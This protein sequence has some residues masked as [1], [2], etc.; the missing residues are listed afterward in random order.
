MVLLKTIYL[1]VYLNWSP[2]TKSQML[3]VF[4]SSS[5]DPQFTDVEGGGVT[6]FPVKITKFN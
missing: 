4:T 3:F 1:K 5:L 2:C 6:H